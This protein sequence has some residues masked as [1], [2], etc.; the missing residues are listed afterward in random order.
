MQLADLFN[1]PAFQ[2]SNRTI[3]CIAAPPGAGM[4]WSNRAAGMVGSNR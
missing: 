2:E 3:T 4:I 1:I